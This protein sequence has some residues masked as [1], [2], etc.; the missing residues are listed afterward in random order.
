MAA[1][2]EDRFAIND[3]FVRYAT[4]L[5]SGDVETIVGCFTEDGSLESPAQFRQGGAQLR[6]VLSNLAVEVTGDRARATCY[7]CNIITMDGRSEMMPP[8]RYECDLQ[9]IN[10]EWLFKHRLVVLD[11]AFQLPGI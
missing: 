6:H 5:D 3:L 2:I 8:G 10:G 7:L 1:S 4:A 11:A 9:R